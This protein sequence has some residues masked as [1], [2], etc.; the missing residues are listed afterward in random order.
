MHHVYALVFDDGSKQIVTAPGPTEAVAA[1]EGAPD[2]P[3]PHTITDLTLL[4]GFGRSWGGLR[5]R[6]GLDSTFTLDEDQ[7]LVLSSN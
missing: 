1:R 5:A 2:S 4:N 3:R 6:L 7:P